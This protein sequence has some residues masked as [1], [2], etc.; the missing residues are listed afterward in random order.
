MEDAPPRTPLAESNR[1]QDAGPLPAKLLDL[2][3]LAK[4]P[5]SAVKK[6]LGLPQASNWVLGTDSLARPSS[7][8]VVQRT[9]APKPARLPATPA[10]NPQ[11]PHRGRGFQLLNRSSA[12]AM[13]RLLASTD[14][15]PSAG[16]APASTL[17]AVA[18]HDLPNANS[19]AWWVQRAGD[20]E[21]A[22]NI[23]VCLWLTAP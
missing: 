2:G 17:R 22:G 8:L 4:T 6:D 7:E 13:T 3:R 1:Q 11:Q 15:L 10:A 14:N 5:R 23:E 21:A 19:A 12:S 9:P 18:L 20:E 16:P